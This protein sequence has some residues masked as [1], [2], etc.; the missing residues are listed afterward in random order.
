[1]SLEIF[2]GLNKVRMILSDPERWG[3]RALAKN[4]GSILC[5]CLLGA[6]HKAMGNITEDRANSRVLIEVPM[7][8]ESVLLKNQ[9]VNVVEDEI[10]KKEGWRCG[11]TNW[12]DHLHRKHS[13]VLE[14]LDKSIETARKM[15]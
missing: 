13:E 12:N 10:A 8:N 1:M 14:I 11:I 6:V 4:N 15:L 9:L 2:D 7:S 5:Y 3:Q